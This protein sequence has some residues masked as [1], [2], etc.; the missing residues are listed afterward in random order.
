MDMHTMRARRGRWSL[1][2]WVGIGVIVAAAAVAASSLL[3]KR[4]TR[5]AP[6]AAAGF[7]AKKSGADRVEPGAHK[8]AL[9][10]LD[11]ALGA[12]YTPAIES[13]L[14]RAYPEAEVPG[15]ATLA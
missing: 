1:T 11:E 8:R 15:E 6:T 4:A 9:V 2:R 13:Y 7:V 14:L 12:D 3:T 5:S 10:A